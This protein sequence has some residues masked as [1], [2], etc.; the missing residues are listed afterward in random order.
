MNVRVWY[1]KLRKL[2]E[3]KAVVLMY[4]RVADLL[5]DPFE[6]SVSTEKFEHQ[7]QSL[8]KNFTILRT[9]E[10]V[11]NLQRG[12]VPSNAVC[13]TFDDGYADNYINALP[14]L[15]KYKCPAT[16]YIT[17]GLIEQPQMYWWDELQYIFLHTP[18]L[19]PKLSININGDVV[20]EVLQNNGVMQTDDWVK[21]RH[22]QFEDE[23]P[24]QRCT[25]FKNIWAKL[26][27]MPHNE[28]RCELDKLR[29]WANLP[30]HF[31]KDYFPMTNEQLKEVSKHPLISLGIHTHTHPSLALCDSQTQNNEIVTC[32][33]YLQHFNIP[34]IPTISY[35]F[36]EFN[37]QTLSI[38]KSE[39]IMGG[40]TTNEQFVTRRTDPLC[41]GRF[42]VKN[43]SGPEFEQHIKSWFKK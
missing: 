29:I 19:P 32:K 41:I 13:I 21:S 40:F 36:G 20:E 33:K 26:K 12:K 35:P 10:I 1:R 30:T 14:I 34:P 37:D 4:H 38:A 43:W 7:I 28:R 25:L 42:Q 3:N 16:F 22:W 17:T 6:L 27:A 2:V 15:E 31:G 9:E 18:I 39:R 5:I 24:T 8:A 23:P 11:H